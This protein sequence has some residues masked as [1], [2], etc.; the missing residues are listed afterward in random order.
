MRATI[1]VGTMGLMS[2]FAIMSASDYWPDL[3]PAQRATTVL[4]GVT[5]AG[6]ML[7]G[8]MGSWKDMLESNFD[9]NVKNFR[10]D[11]Q[12]ALQFWDIS[13]PKNGLNMKSIDWVDIEY[14]QEDVM[15]TM[16]KEGKK[17][18]PTMSEEEW[19]KKIN[20]A[21]DDFNKRKPRVT[22][23]AKVAVGFAMLAATALSIAFTVTLARAQIGLM[24]AGMAIE[25]ASVAI[26]T[27]GLF[28]GSTLALCIPYIGHVYSI[29]WRHNCRYMTPDPIPTPDTPN[30]GRQN[31]PDGPPP[32]LL[33]P[34]NLPWDVDAEGFP[35]VVIP[36]GE[37]FVIR[38]RGII[39]S[40][41]KY[42]DR[43]NMKGISTLDVIENLSSGDKT[44]TRMEIQ[45]VE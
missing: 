19:D 20:E 30:E 8:V 40:I 16:E 12:A 38:I 44:L 35:A 31:D 5:A 6:Y 39:N 37:G 2:V 34:A 7:S 28:A 32:P 18:P 4:S 3:T 42:P 10:I 14:F 9:K 41:P 11:K 43:K 33:D 22:M 36:P 25:V 29:H 45:R 23:Q 27:F 13:D 17:S 24:W 21:G 26:G 15:R 1:T